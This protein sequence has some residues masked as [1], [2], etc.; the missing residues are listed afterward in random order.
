MRSHGSRR[1]GGGRDKRRQENGR[2]ASGATQVAGTAALSILCG[3]WRYAPIHAVRGD[4]L[5]PPLLGMTHVVSEDVCAG[6]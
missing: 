4:T 2:A 5:N 6:R 1:G 3:H